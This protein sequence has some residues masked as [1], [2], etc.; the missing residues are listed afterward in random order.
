L[1]R[2]ERIDGRDHH[3]EMTD[4]IKRSGQA[5]G[6]PYIFKHYTDLAHKM[7]LGINAAQLRDERGAD[8]KAQAIDYMS[9]DEIQ[10]VNKAKQKLTV[11]IDMGWS[12]QRI[13]REVTV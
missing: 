8:K 11:L 5:D 10:E 1:P 13:K 9:T 12:Y 4:A 3:K 2:R 6:K 7:A